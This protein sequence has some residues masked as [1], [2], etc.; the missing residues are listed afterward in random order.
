MVKCSTNQWHHFSK[1]L[2]ALSNHWGFQS[3]Q[4]IVFAAVTLF[5]R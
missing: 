1:S 3:M 4:H 2:G 5:Q